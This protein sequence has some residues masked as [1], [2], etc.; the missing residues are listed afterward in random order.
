MG[1]YGQAAVSAYRKIIKDG[2]RRESAWRQSI[3]A[4]TSSNTSQTKGC[5]KNTFLGLCNLGLL[6]GVAKDTYAPPDENAKYAAT[7]VNELRANPELAEDKN[8]LWEHVM[9]H[10]EPGKK[11][12]GQMDVVTALWEIGA[13]PSN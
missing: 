1:Q 3:K 4:V 7:A 6:V 5:P 13:I 10:F 9:V 2:T 11:H 8:L 12:N